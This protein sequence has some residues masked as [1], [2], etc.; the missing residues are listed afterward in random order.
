MNLNECSI[1]N[2]D[3]THKAWASLSEG[4]DMIPHKPFGGILSLSVLIDSPI[5]YLDQDQIVHG[6]LSELLLGL[7][8]PMEYWPVRFCSNQLPVVPTE[9]G[10]GLLECSFSRAIMLNL[11]L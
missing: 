4:R 6:L 5:G 1:W 7:C 11:S 10:F 9:T 8:T 3:S 2:D